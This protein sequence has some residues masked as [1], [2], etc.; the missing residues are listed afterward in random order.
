MPGGVV[1]GNSDGDG[2]V[3]VVAGEVVDERWID[4][5]YAPGPWIQ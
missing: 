2:V 3:V 5:K 4:S 1:I